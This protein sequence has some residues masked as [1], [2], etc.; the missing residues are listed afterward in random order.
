MK[1]SIL[2]ILSAA[3]V[4]YAALNVGRFGATNAF[5][6]TQLNGSGASVHSGYW[7]PEISL[8]TDPEK[9]DGDNG[10]Y[11]TPPCVTLRAD[12]HG[13]TDK[14]KIYYK[15]SHD[16][17]PKDNGEEYAGHCVSVPD[18]HSVD[19]EA[20]AVN[21]DN[22]NWRSET[23]KT[24]FQ[25]DTAA[26]NVKII[27]PDD[28]DIVSGKIDIKAD[29][30]DDNLGKYSVYVKDGPDAVEKDTDNDAENFSDKVVDSWDTTQVSDGEYVIEIDGTDQAG[31]ASHHS[32]TVQ[33]KNIP[34]I[35][36][37]DVILNELMW[38]GSASDSNDEWI[39]LRNT[40]G[41]DID[42][43]NWQIQNGGT[44]TGAGAHLEIPHGYTIKA[45]GYFLIFEKKWNETAVR[46]DK[47]LGKDE[48]MTNVAGLNLK[49]A[50]EQLVLLDAD[51]N[52]IDRAGDGG[53]WPA[54]SAGSVKA[55][56]ERKNDPGDGTA[57]SA[58]KTCADSNASEYWNAGMTELGTPRA[59]NL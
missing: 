33:V 45:H 30:K 4:I 41:R 27:S 16:G 5:F 7:I 39:E 34:E 11:E 50:G 49:N 19:F 13:E 42:L 32:V 15:F 37:G 58:W 25:V 57:D 17:D 47:D 22:E 35:K 36:A 23:L 9:P 55:S 31:N 21:T 29:Y 2:K 51:K 52:V 54:G 28:G 10:F 44:G 26:P 1:T 14:V 56:M 46:L 24:S 8:A 59:D 40:T 53:S 48:G 12:I 18:G 6:T 43:S 20:V 38:M 3:F